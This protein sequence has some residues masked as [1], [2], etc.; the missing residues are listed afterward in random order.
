MNL[1][2]KSGS[3]DSTQP[4][5]VSAK[6]SAYTFSNVDDTSDTVTYRTVTYDVTN[7]Y[8]IAINGTTYKNLPATVAV[9]YDTTDI[10][11]VRFAAESFANLNKGLKNNY[12]AVT[13]VKIDLTGG[14]DVTYKYVQT[15]S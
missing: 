1:K 4:H 6:A 10:M 13:L 2:Q 3:Y 9:D 11:T 5:V 7:E 12:D 14:K 15:P 8:D